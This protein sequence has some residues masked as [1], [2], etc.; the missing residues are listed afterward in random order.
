MAG[1][2]NR[3]RVR[4]EPLRS[5]RRVELL[6]LVVAVL[7]GLQ[8]L[9]TGVRLA[10]LSAPAP[11]APA[12]SSLEVAA[13]GE[14]ADVSDSESDTIKSRPLFW[15]GRRPTV[16]PVVTAKPEEKTVATKSGNI[17]N[18][19]LRGVFGSGDSAGIIALVDGKKQRIR[20][21]D[22]VNGWTLV[23]VKPDRGVF[24]SD[25]RKRALVLERKKSSAG[26]AASENK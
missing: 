15:R 3:Y 6:V 8:L 14:P 22:E 11:L 16:A 23:A 13:V 20:V 25:G 2:M 10:T 18:V 17:D 9:Y 7:L 1:W 24:E 19:K 4:E 21:G 12:P 26:L 5:E